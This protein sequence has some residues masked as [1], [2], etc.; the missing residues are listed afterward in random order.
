M[1]HFENT[2]D[3]FEQAIHSPPG[4][5][6]ISDWADVST[7]L[8]K[9]TAGRRPTNRLLNVQM[10]APVQDSAGVCVG[11]LVANVMTRQLLDLLEDMKQRAPGDEFPCL[12]DKTGRVLMSTDPQAL[13]CFR[14]HPDATSGALRTPLNSRDDGYLVYTDS[15]G[16]KLM[17]GYTT[18]WTYGANKAGDW[19]LI[20]WLPT[21]PS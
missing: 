19:R 4:S 10:L 5:V 2:R 6:F 15:H 18:L 14:S 7:R 21:T 8:S 16:Q 9:P 3:E 13:V 20:A 12:L 11:V 17:A 1:T